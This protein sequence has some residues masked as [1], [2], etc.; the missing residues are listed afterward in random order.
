MQNLFTV[1]IREKK[2]TLGVAFLTSMILPKK[3]IGDFFY[4]KYMFNA[5]MDMILSVG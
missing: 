3:Q 1:Y 5:N 2:A 4:M